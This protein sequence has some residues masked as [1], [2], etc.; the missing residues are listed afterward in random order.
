[1][2]CTCRIGTLKASRNPCLDDVDELTIV[3]CGQCLR[4]EETA[5]ERDRLRTAA[6]RFLKSVEA[7]TA[8]IGNISASTEKAIELQ[9]DAE[10]A[11]TELRR[12]LFAAPV[13]T[14]PS[15]PGR[16][17]MPIESAPRD[18]SRVLMWYPNGGYYIGLEW[19]ERRARWEDGFDNGNSFKDAELSHWQPV[20]PPAASEGRTP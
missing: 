15:K 2:N 11:E 3:K 5:A 20:E 16:E 4:A 6:I 10:D 8:I 19:N 9:R 14:E 1:M 18:G 17:W 12:I 7:Y 13:A